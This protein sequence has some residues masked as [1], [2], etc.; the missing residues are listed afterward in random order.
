[1]AMRCV[2]PWCQALMRRLATVFFS[3][4]LLVITAVVA[5]ADAVPPDPGAG[6]ITLRGGWTP[7][8]PYQIA[9]AGKTGALAGIDIEITMAVA[10]SADLVTELSLENWPTQLSQLATGAADFAFGAVSSAG[11]EEEFLVSVPYR[12]MRTAFYVRSEDE[13]QYALDDVPALLGRDEG[14]RVGLVAGRNFADPAL[15]AAIDRAGQQRQL[16]FAQSEDQNLR[17]LVEGRVDGV[18]GDRMALATAALAGGLKVL[19]HE[20]VLPGTA[21][22]RFLFS[23]HTVSPETVARIDAAIGRLKADGTIERILNSKIFTTIIAYTFD[24]MLFRSVD[25]IG[26]IAFA[27]SGVLI[28]YRERFSLLGAL[29]ISALPAVGGGVLRDLLVNRHPLGVMRT[30]LYLCLVG[31]TVLT[32][33]LV[34]LL[35]RHAK[36]RNWKIMRFAGKSKSAIFTNL[37]EFSDALGMGMYTVYGV[38]VA[39]AMDVRPLWLWGPILAMVTAAGGG[40]LRDIVRQ[41]GSVASLKGE[42]YAEVPLIWGF[43][44]SAFLVTRQALDGPEYVGLAIIGT[45]AGAFLSRVAVVMLG[46]RSPAFGWRND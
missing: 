20:T 8:P 16:V 2:Q 25:I 32:G 12:Q 38:S 27:I 39:V 14:I 26:T 9:P 11:G 43:L 17:N 34:I 28:A 46:L 23:R 7:N 24:T 41:S 15:S 37:H 13:Q 5:A 21:D 22:V 10:R 40:M 44:F 3:L 31:L 18:V 33:L 30:P 45:V 42:F 29:V 35:L 36:D 1:M 4:A 6:Q 19:V